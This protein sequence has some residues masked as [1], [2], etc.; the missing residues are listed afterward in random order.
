LFSTCTLAFNKCH[1]RTGSLFEHPFH[2]IV[3]DNDMY[4]TRLID[5]RISRAAAGGVG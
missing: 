1:G 3:V 4:F 5:S 2:R